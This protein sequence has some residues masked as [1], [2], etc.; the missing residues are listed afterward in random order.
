[1]RVAALE[2]ESAMV[3]AADE[4]NWVWAFGLRPADDA[5]TRLVSRNR[6]NSPGASSPVR[7]VRSLVE[8]P[9]SPVMERKMLLGIK[10]RAERLAGASD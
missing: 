10:A 3:L 9:G 5:G 6:I 8:E 7:V 1:M 2:P 4:G